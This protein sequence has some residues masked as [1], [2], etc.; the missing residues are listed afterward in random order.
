MM[1]FMTILALIPLVIYDVATEINSLLPFREDIRAVFPGLISIISDDAIESSHSPPDFILPVAQSRHHSVISVRTSP[2]FVVYASFGCMSS[3]FADYLRTYPEYVSSTVWN[4][5]LVQF[6][7]PIAVHEQVLAV[8]RDGR[9]TFFEFR[10][11][12]RSHIYRHCP[13]VIVKM[14]TDIQIT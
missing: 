3:Q 8:W 11:D 5:F 13:S 12:S 9:K 6:G 10:V 4:W 1:R 2:K 14:K 7:R